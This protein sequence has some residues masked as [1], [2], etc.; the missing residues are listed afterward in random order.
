MMLFFSIISLNSL[1]PSGSVIYQAHHNFI[2][3]IIIVCA[4]GSKKFLS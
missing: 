3:I 4:H 2:I 1:D